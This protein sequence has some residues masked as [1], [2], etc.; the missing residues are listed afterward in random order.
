MLVLDNSKIKNR[1]KNF[2]EKSDK[3]NSKKIYNSCISFK[4]I[5]LIS[6]SQG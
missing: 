5:L 6:N 1:R 2:K 4:N 3:F